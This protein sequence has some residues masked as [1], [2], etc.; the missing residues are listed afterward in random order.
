MIFGYVH[1]FSYVLGKNIG[2]KIEQNNV[3]PF[4]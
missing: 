4:L 1:F 3:K 2:V